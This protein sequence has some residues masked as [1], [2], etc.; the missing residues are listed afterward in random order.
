MVLPIIIALFVEYRRR[1]QGSLSPFKAHVPSLIMVAVL[2]IYA[3]VR[4]RLQPSML[5]YRA[6]DDVLVGASLWEKVGYGLELLARYSGLVA[7]PTGLSP[8]ESSPRCFGHSMS[9]LS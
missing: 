7:A 2:A 1:S 5:S 8:G 9:H 6:P 3:V 4:L